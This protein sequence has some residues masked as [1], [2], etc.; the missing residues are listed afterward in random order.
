M[1]PDSKGRLHKKVA[2]Y[3]KN[4]NSKRKKVFVTN[5]VFY[6]NG[7]ISNWVEFRYIK[8]NNLLGRSDGDYDMGDNFI[9]VS[10]I[11]KQKIIIP[12]KLLKL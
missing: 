7:G 2:T 10:R 1:I 12:K 3:R 4:R 11:P 9:N 8:S 5:H 6:A